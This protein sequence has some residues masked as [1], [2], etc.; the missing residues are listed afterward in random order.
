M[1]A[2]F[3]RLAPL[4]RLRPFL[5]LLVVAGLGLTA[6]Q[7]TPLPP[8]RIDQ[9]KVN[10]PPPGPDFTEDTPPDPMRETRITP[11]PGSRVLEPARS[12]AAP[13]LPAG[14]QQLQASF[15]QMPLP[16]FINTVF[17]EM[18]KV[19]FQMD[20]AV[21]ARQELVTLRT[22]GGRTPEQL[23]GV[24]REVLATYGIQVVQTDNLFRIVPN[25][26]MMQQ[27]PELVK[28][29]TAPDVPTD[30]R[31]VF[32]YYQF[33]E[34]KIADVLAA[35]TNIVSTKVR[36]FPLP[37]ANAVLL[38]GL[39]DDVQ[40]VVR[41]LA[42]LDKA[43]F[44]T[45]MSVRIDPVFWS[46]TPLAQRLTEILKAQGY[47]VGGASGEASAISI[48][49]VPQVN[50][51]LVFAP[52]RQVLDLAARWARDLDRPQENDE[53]QKVFVYF[54]RNTK[55]VGI[56]EVVSSVIEGNTGTGSSG[57]TTGSGG[58][59]GQSASLA[60]GSAATASPGGL[61]SGATTSS[62]ANGANAKSASR[63]GRLVVDE[64]RNAVIF[65]GSATEW[66]R[67]RPLIE[68]L[69]VPTREVLIEVSVLEV[70]LTDKTQFGLQWLFSGN[71]DGNPVT[72]GTLNPAAPPAQAAGGLNIR[73][74]NSASELRGALTALATNSRV[75]VLSNPRLLARSGAEAKIQIGQD[76]PTISSQGQSTVGNSAV[77]QSI[78]Y[79][80]TGV[81]LS[82]KPIIHAGRRVDL[83]VNQEVSNIDS[84]L[85]SAVTGV[86][87][88]G[89][90]NRKV[91]TQLAL[92]DGATV[93]LGGLISENRS[94]GD[95]GIPFL[96]DLPLIGQAF[97]SNTDD[98]D[99]TELIVLITPYVI[100]GPD[101]L[102]ALTDAYSKHI[103]ATG[104]DNQVN[105][106]LLPQYFGKSRP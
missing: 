45:N 69:D 103:E 59:A 75:N 24:A 86:N 63:S 27:I 61:G 58:A 91:S 28:T 2:L 78:Q 57:S 81:V 104:Y 42:S 7:P 38:L 48:I 37:S 62:G 67:Y 90:S 41:M 3:R 54:V 23:L 100:S 14:T 56:A 11:G 97:R 43:Y 89:F 33:R 64:V 52:N 102:Q 25:D 9:V 49:P 95:S 19:N 15:D 30:L 18:L 105:L 44:A 6:C 47:S 21:A 36:L 31:P 50:A 70:R 72:I 53:S 84:S 10:R 99:R 22:S 94:I 8:T 65:S 77:L 55:A 34:V 74:F 71:V 88:P 12:P 29:R 39:P 92:L 4:A 60:Q 46:A 106:P 68:Q 85:T 5:L 20:P 26:V 87:S 73:V 83:E 1:P 93:I 16:A 98:R 96:K 82:V 35:V 40:A 32:Q 101:D 51:V 66:S 76:V 80:Q 79:R 13:R 17:G